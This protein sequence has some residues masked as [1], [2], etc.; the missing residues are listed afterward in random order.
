MLK[1]SA[2]PGLSIRGLSIT[3]GEQRM[4][5]D[6]DLSV[7][8]GEILGLV[9][10]SG[11][12]KS[13][14][15]MSVLDVL[16]AGIRRTGSIDFNGGALRRGRDI[17]IVFQE[18]MTAL[19]PLMTI[20]A[21]V[22]EVLRIDT[23]AAKQEALEEACAALARVGLGN[24]PS[25]SYPHQLSGGQRQ[26]AMI[27]M[28]IVGKPK[29]LL[30][31]EPTTALDMATQAEITTL[32]VDLARDTGCALIFVSHDLPLVA[33]LADQLAILHCGQIV[34]RGPTQR[35][36]GNLQHPYSKRL[37][38]AALQRPETPPDAM[39]DAI[40]DVRDLSARYGDKVA[41]DQVSFKVPQAGCTALIGQSGCGKSTL[42]RA[43][44]ALQPIENGTVHV[45]GKPFTAPRVAPSRTQR[46][47]VQIVFQDPYSSF[48]PR[49]SVQR[50]LSE[51][52]YLLNRKPDDA[53]LIA[54]LTDVGLDA[55]AL[56]R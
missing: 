2:E 53:Q 13:L 51:P 9:G 45:A 8:P 55:D 39:Q 46:R 6:L 42:A 44:L 34:E 27:A 50:I 52:Y 36:L 30:A 10:E 32:L 16:P 24:V 47:D 22:A 41:L 56:Q 5:H 21:Q 4:V 31:D 38:A 26:R 48:N 15:L 11:S 25:G 18:P 33:S 7:A 28:A 49:H 12:G 43:L 14:F 29:V 3:R 20:A 40:L 17:G 1:G 19:N 23:R 35:L 37:F 54:A